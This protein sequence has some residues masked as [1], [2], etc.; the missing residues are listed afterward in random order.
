MPF[1]IL[2][3]FRYI[4]SSGRNRT[5]K[6]FQVFRLP[7]RP[8]HRAFPSFPTVAYCGFC[9]RL[10][11]RVRDGIQP[12]SLFLWFFEFL[13][14][15]Y[16]SSKNTP[17]KLITSFITYSFALRTKKIPGFDQLQSN[18]GMP[19]FILD[20]V[21]CVHSSRREQSNKFFHRSSGFRIV[22]ITAPSHRF[23]Q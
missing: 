16:Y 2:D 18:P 14:H 12:S 15:M 23:R 11:R 5:E 17:Y 3:N 21:R 7:D 22:L 9:P 1:F 4:Q 8:T 6:S 20:N 10:R 19:F 13:C